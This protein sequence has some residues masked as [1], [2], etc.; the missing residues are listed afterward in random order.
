[1]YTYMYVCVYI[2]IY[3]HMYMYKCI[4]I[5]IYIYIHILRSAMGETI[6]PIHLG[7]QRM[8]D[9]GNGCLHSPFSITDS[10]GFFFG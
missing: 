4:Y 2:Y 8:R 1:M 5:Y 7:P 10:R 9:E 6:L 3:I